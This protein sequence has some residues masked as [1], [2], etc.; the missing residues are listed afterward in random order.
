MGATGASISGGFFGA[1]KAETARGCI[2]AV[3]TG[4]TLNNDAKEE[5]F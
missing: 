3:G 5:P 1:G 2:V 4:K